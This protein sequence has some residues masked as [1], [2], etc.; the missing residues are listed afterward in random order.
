MTGFG[1][2]WLSIIIFTISDI[3]EQI[4]N[5]KMAKLAKKNA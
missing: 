3:R 1:V 5:E 4:H 2:I